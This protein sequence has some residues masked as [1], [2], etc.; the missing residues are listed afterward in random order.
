MYKDEVINTSFDQH[1]QENQTQNI[2]SSNHNKTC[3]PVYVRSD[4]T[5]I[6]QAMLGTNFF[7]TLFIYSI[8]SIY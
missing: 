7:C 5:R 4:R 3:M 1:L 2:P 8:N 6:E